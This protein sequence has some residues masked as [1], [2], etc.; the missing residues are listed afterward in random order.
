MGV[1]ELSMVSGIGEAELPGRGIGMEWEVP[2]QEHEQGGLSVH[3]QRPAL[4]MCSDPIH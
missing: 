3:C 4:L 2:L 1:R